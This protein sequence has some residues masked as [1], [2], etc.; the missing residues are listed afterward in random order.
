MWIVIGKPKT[1]INWK[2]KIKE[3]WIQINAFIQIQL[4]CNYPMAHSN[5][6]F[7]EILTQSQS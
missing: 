7:E 5:K 3:A 1:Y 6:K 2:Q 4:S